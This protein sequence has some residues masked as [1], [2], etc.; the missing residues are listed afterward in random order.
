MTQ[1]SANSSSRC[2]LSQHAGPRILS[3]YDLHHVLGL[4]KAT[5]APRYKGP[6]TRQDIWLDERKK[7]LKAV[8]NKFYVSFWGADVSCQDIFCSLKMMVNIDVSFPTS[9]RLLNWLARGAKRKNLNSFCDVCRI[10]LCLSLI[11][12]LGQVKFKYLIN[13]AILNSIAN[14]R[15]LITFSRGG[16]IYEMSLKIVYPQSQSMAAAFPPECLICCKYR[17]RE[18]WIGGRQLD[19]HMWFLQG[20]GARWK[21][22]DQWWVSVYCFL[23]V[24]SRAAAEAC[25]GRDVW[26]QLVTFEVGL[27]P[28]LLIEGRILL[29]YRWKLSFFNKW[30]QSV[31]VQRRALHFARIDVHV[32]VPC[33]VLII[34]H[35]KNLC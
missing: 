19:A 8:G 33:I 15:R 6:S 29:L 32:S 35:E 25:W 22:I 14:R 21:G 4:F 2:N 17:K 34:L 3:V 13:H 23:E 20:A 18:I 28:K 27:R 5:C 24:P 7:S 30:F 1:T 10:F 16:S 26:S 31:C 12:N 11:F 9:G